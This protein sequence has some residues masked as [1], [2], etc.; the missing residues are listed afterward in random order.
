M[1]PMGL[2]DSAKRIRWALGDHPSSSREPEADT[3]GFAQATVYSLLSLTIAVHEEN[4]AN[5][6][7]GSRYGKGQAIGS[8][9]A[10]PDCNPQRL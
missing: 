3:V 10:R 6:L 8:R 1:Q 5:N 9:V 2:A 7:G 4:G